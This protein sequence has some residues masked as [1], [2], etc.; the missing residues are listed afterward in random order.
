[1][2]NERST[3]RLSGIDPRLANILMMARERS[4]IPFEI[5]E[6]MRDQQRQAE[7]VNAGKSR[8]FN[9]HHGSGGALDI[10]IPDGK[11]GVNWDFEA[12]RPI[13]EAAK[14][15]AKEQGIDEFVWGGDWET[16][17]DGVHFQIGEAPQRIA[18]DTMAG[19]GVN[20][21]SRGQPMGLLGPGSAPQ[22]EKPKQSVLERMTGGFLTPDR[23]DRLAIGLQGMTMNPNEALMRNAQ[24]NISGR[25]DQRKTQEQTNKTVALLERM[26][27]DPKLIEAARNGYAKEA[28]AMAF[29]QPEAQKGIAVGDRI[30]NPVTGEVIYDGAGSG[31]DP[32]GEAK[33][34][35]EFTSLPIVKAFSSQSTAYGRVIA[36]VDDP[37]PAGD[38]ALI[39][40]FMKVL[41]PGSTVREGEFATAA[42]SGGVDDRVRAL[43][44][45]VVDGT[46]L[47]GSQR[48]DFAN[49]ATRLY[50]NAEQQYR[51]IADQYGQFAANAGFDPAAMMPDFGY[52][53]DKYETPLSLSPPQLTGQQ[54]GQLGVKL[55]DWPALWQSFTDS[56]REQFMED[57]R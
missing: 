9:S 25:A 28:V 3:S 32:E 22:Q 4:G 10:H 38:L 12:Y 51:S 29:A 2:F 15:I 54:L 42:N 50:G 5:S 36:S 1:M 16:L 14:A 43:Y 8:T 41:D 24:A 46:R 26:G 21:Q 27:A 13:A 19:L 55:A 20:Q 35:K 6:G 7:L 37:S 45:N 53:G 18:A 57:M 49:R 34:R 39:F 31:G 23:R 48:D 30:V 33:L 17:R 40:N 47:S 56:E 44:N 52:S 11:G